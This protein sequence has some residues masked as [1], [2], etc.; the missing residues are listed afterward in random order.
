[1]SPDVYQTKFELR[2]APDT[3]VIHCSDPWYQ[4]HFQEFLREHLGLQTYELLAVPGGPQF[5]T[6]AEYLPKFSWAGWRWMKFLLDV[7]NPTRIILITHEDCRW[8]SDSRF[9]ALGAGDRQHK[10][11]DLERV[12]SDILARFKNLHIDLYLARLEG[13]HAIFEQC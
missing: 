11:R 1:M 5:L 10:M 8:Y 7:A 13:G 2:T 4:P 6:L 3:L 12:R 9:L